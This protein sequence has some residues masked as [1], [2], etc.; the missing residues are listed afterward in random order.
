MDISGTADVTA[1]DGP[2]KLQ[3]IHVIFLNMLKYTWDY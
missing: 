2:S 1:A 3:Y